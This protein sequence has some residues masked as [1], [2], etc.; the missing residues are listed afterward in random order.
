MSTPTPFTQK[1]GKEVLRLLHTVLLKQEEHDERFDVIENRMNGIDSR[2]D[3]L[4]SRL[5]ARMDGLDAR[6]DGLAI[7]ME[8]NHHDL[9]DMIKESNEV[10]KDKH[11]DHE[12][13][14]VRLEH[15]CGLAV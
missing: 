13:R 10:L 4:E 9:V 11:I 1:D 3:G 12:R 2:I 6:M 14:I 15:G 8:L 5:D 7:K